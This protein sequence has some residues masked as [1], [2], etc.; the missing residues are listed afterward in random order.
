MIQGDLFPDRRMAAC[1]YCDG[2]T[3]LQLPA[4]L[5]A[6]GCC[7]EPW[8]CQACGS[9]G[10]VSTRTSSVTAAQRASVGR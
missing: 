6:S 2:A 8:A 9:A 7:Q 3:A 10:H 1:P 4:Y 5:T